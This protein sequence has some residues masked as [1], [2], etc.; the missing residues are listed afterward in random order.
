[1]K[2]PQDLVQL[3]G[4]NSQE[5]DTMR[6]CQPKMSTEKMHSGFDPLSEI[7][8]RLGIPLLS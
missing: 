3:E 5:T 4:V 6:R 2:I 7:R 1:M 8:R